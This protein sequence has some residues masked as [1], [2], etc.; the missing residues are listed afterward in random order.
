MD[1]PKLGGCYNDFAR[2]CRLNSRGYRD[3][4]EGFAIKG[5]SSSEEISRQ[6]FDRQAVR[7][8]SLV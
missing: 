8:T 6:G 4:R 2:H 7:L 3:D 5:L 1:G